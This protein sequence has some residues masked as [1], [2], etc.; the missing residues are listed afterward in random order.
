MKANVNPK[1]DASIKDFLYKILNKEAGDKSGKI[2]GLGHAVYTISDPRAVLL[3]KY[4]RHMAEIKG[5]D[6][7]FQLLEKIEEL[8]IPM[9]QN[10]TGSDMP[11]CANVDMYSGL[12]YTMLGIPEDVFT[13]LFASAVS[14]AGAPTGSRR[15]SPA[16]GSCGRPTGPWS[17]GCTTSPCPPGRSTMPTPIRKP[18]PSHHQPRAQ[19]LPCARFVVFGRI[20]G[21]ETIK[22]KET[23]E[24]CHKT[25]C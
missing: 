9:I 4:A 23:L 25:L 20:F 24:R 3:K 10:K 12:V 19:A 6:E 16:T 1:D 17:S 5:Y 7:D 13:P 22:H 18:L 11:M 15:F 2:Y 21:L 8:G 14:P